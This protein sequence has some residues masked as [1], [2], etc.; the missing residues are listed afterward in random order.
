M[1]AAKSPRSSPKPERTIPFS[2]SNF[3]YVKQAMVKV[4]QPGGTAWR[5]GAGLQYSMG[6]KTG[7]AQVVQIQQGKSYNAAALASN[8]AIT[9]GLFRLRRCK[10][11]KSPLPCCWKTA[12]GAPQPRPWRANSPIITCSSS[13]AVKTPPSAKPRSAV[14][15]PSTTR[16]LAASEPAA[17]PARRSISPFQTAYDAVHRPAS[18]ILPASGATP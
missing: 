18:D 16:F 12:A 10:P 1:S 17:A 11:R 5:V 14:H 7:T 2:R 3:E 4:L 13:K 6:G 9:P 15:K 8:T